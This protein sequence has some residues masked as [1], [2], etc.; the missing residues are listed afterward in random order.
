MSNFVT[1]EQIFFPNFTIIGSV[2]FYNSIKFA[3]LYFLNKK[4][5]YEYESC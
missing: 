3:Q 2:L 4:R 1:F 5:P